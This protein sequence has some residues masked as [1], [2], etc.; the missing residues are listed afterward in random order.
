MKYPIEYRYCPRCGKALSEGLFMGEE[1][2]LCQ[3]CG[4]VHFADPKVSVL[5]MIEDQDKILL[6]RRKHF[7]EKGLWSLPSGFVDYGEDPV[8][9]AIREVEEETGLTIRINKLIDV[10]SPRD[11]GGIHPT[12]LILYEGD[13]RGG[14]LKAG[15]DADEALFFSPQSIPFRDLAFPNTERLLKKWIEEKKKASS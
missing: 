13:I 7:P 9:S 12:I 5:A 14:T 10:L 11:S 3:T 8:E 1:R 6:I 15:D 2:K 4:F